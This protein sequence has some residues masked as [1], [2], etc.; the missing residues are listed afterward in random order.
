MKAKKQNI[1]ISIGDLVHYCP[2]DMSE[3]NHDIGIIYEIQ[4]I[5]HGQDKKTKIYK[6][7]WSRSKDYDDY[8][9]SGLHN[10]LKMIIRN[11]NVFKIIKQNV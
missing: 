10:R 1:S 9:E 4:E 8:P 6:I 5:E 11:Q 2:A 3:K 7:F